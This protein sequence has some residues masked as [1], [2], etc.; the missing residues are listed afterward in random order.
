VVI[1]TDVERSDEVLHGRVPLRKAGGT[2]A[3]LK[4]D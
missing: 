4:M 2:V 3:A 1:V